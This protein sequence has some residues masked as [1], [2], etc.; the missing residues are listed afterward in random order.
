MSTCT[1]RIFR[2]FIGSI[3]LYYG[4]LSRGE[5]L[6]HAKSAKKRIRRKGKLFSFAMQSAEKEIVELTEV[7]SY[8]QQKCIGDS[9]G[10]NYQDYFGSHFLLCALSKLCVSYVCVKS[11]NYFESTRVAIE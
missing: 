7:L 6:F 2:N 10:T 11:I 3:L 1:Y 8:Y 9:V 5:T 4:I